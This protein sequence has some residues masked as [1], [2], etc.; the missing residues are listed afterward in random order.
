MKLDGDPLV[1][2]ITELAFA[3]MGNTHQAW[4]VVDCDVYERPPNCNPSTLLPG[5]LAADDFNA[6]GTAVFQILNLLRLA[7]A[8]AAADLILGKRRGKATQT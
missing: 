1:S 4:G 6:F 7:P 5:N 8:R 3:R 2:V